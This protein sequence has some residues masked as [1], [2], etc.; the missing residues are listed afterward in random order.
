MSKTKLIKELNIN[1]NDLHAC[2]YFGT[3]YKIK[4]RLGFRITTKKL[5]RGEYLYKLVLEKN[6][7]KIYD[8]GEKEIGK[9][10][11]PEGKNTSL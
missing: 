11:K 6:T 2:A 5:L 10:R 7:I 3:V 4:T 8:N 9:T 1:D